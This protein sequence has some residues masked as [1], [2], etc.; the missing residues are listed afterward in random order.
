MVLPSKE[1]IEDE[2][3][4]FV[5]LG[6][7]NYLKQNNLHTNSRSDDFFIR[8]KGVSCDA[9]AILRVSSN[10]RSRG[11]EHPPELFFKM[12]SVLNFH[13]VR[14]DD[15]GNE[16]DWVPAEQ[17]GMSSAPSSQASVENEPSNAIETHRKFESTRWTRDH[18]LALK[19]KRDA[20][21]VIPPQNNWLQK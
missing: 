10:D 13:I 9:K 17:M 2:L 3:D 4:K 1:T 7:D 19:R 18:K 6:C 12:P 8:W 20:E 5:E 11:L 15:D 21:L 16:T 14:R